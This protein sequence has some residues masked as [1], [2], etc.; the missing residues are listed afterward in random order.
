MKNYNPPYL[1]ETN[2]IVDNFFWQKTF[3]F[4]AG[5]QITIGG[6]TNYINKETTSVLYFIKIMGKA[7]KE[8]GDNET[9]KTIG[10]QIIKTGKNTKM[11]FINRSQ[12]IKKIG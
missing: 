10:L 6:L 3:L 12:T 7:A 11:G 9:K 1:I 2:A 8:I 4:F 5:R